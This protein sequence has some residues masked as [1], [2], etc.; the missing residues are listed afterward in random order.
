[1]VRM[2]VRID[3]LQRLHRH[4][5]EARR[6]PDVDPRL[7]Q[8]GRTCAS[9]CADLRRQVGL[10]DTRRRGGGAGAE[11]A[12]CEGL[13]AGAGGR[14]RR[15]FAA[16]DP[17]LSPRRSRGAIDRRLGG[18]DG[19]CRYFQCRVASAPAPERRRV[20]APGRGGAG[21]RCAASQPRPPDPHH[22]RDH[23]PKGGSG[24]QA[25][26]QAVAHSQRL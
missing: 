5:D 4:A 14:E 15:G 6:L 10:A 16:P 21:R 3:A 1:M 18:R 7:H 2:V 13:L 22:R 17:D 12:R 9:T 8:P 23:G 26:Q 25:G 19:A 24:G 20:G 11:R